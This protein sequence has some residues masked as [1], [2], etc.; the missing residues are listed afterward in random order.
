MGRRTRKQN[1]GVKGNT[2]S[3]PDQKAFKSDSFMNWRP[4]LSKEDAD[5]RWGIRGIPMRAAPESKSLTT[6]A[7]IKCFMKH[8]SEVDSDYLTKITA[9]NGEFKAPLIPFDSAT[10]AATPQEITIYD[11]TPTNP[12]FTVIFNNNKPNMR[13]T[14]SIDNINNTHPWFNFLEKNWELLTAGHDGFNGCWARL[15]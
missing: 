13:S 2:V 8:L 7:Q 9:M 10:G 1:G 12:T 5:R 6:P 14:T 3:W 15:S 4:P 11:T